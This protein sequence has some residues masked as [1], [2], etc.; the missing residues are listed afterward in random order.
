VQ[1]PRGVA[2][3]LVVVLNA[4]ARTAPE[5]TPGRLAPVL[6][7]ESESFTMYPRG[8][9]EPYRISVGLPPSYARESERRFPVL[10]GLDADVGFASLVE[11]TRFL[12]RS[13]EIPEVI[14][15]GIGYDADFATWRSR[16]AADLTPV[17]TDEQPTSG[18]ASEFLDFIATEL[19]PLVESRYRTTRD[20]TL[21]G[22]SLG[23]LFGTYVLFHRPELF[24]RYVLGSPS[25]GWADRVALEWPAAVSPSGPQPSGIVFTSVG[26]LETA[27]MI[28]NWRAFWDAVAALG[29]PWLRVTRGEID[30]TH[31]GGWP[32][33]TVKGLKA[34]WR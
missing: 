2:L 25:Y 28:A 22:Y 20:R 5:A 6:V 29:L 16:R 7:P 8:G 18:H 1:V 12:A 34:I 10:Y 4:C 30:E 27:A 19:I 32:H 3:A 33:T 13:R 15:V 23:G 21:S 17:S 31:A 11:V 9:G 26:T 14:V 24:Q